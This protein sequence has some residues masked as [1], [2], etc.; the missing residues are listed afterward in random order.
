[1]NKKLKLVLTRKWF[2]MILSGEKKEEYRAI[3]KSVVS[4]LFD[5]KESGLSREQFTED[6][7]EYGDNSDLWV[8]LKDFNDDMTFYHAYSTNRDK[9]DIEFLSVSIGEA[10]P[11]WSDNWK[12]NV[13]I[14]KLGEIK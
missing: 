1:M 2:D 12:G 8:F 13:F 10:K 4:L 14:I 11:E 7:N 3:K 6:L 9:F 5:W